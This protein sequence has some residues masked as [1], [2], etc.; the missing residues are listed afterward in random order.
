MKLFQRIEN[1][2][3]IERL[4][5]GKLKKEKKNVILGIELG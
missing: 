2:L 1:T 3:A 5:L 4:V